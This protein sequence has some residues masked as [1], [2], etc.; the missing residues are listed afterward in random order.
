MNSVK[1]IL[2]LTV[3][4]LML[5]LIFVGCSSD[6]KTKTEYPFFGNY[7]V[8]EVV[9]SMVNNQGEVS[10]S[11]ELS[12]EKFIIYSADKTIGDE[13]TDPEYIEQ[14][15][16]DEKIV[17]DYE[18]ID[19]SQYSSKKLYNITDPQSNESHYRIYLLDDDIWFSAYDYDE[20]RQQDQIMYIY[21][22]REYN[23]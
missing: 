7:I 8:S 23:K 3:S 22:L 20:A 1:K 4:I 18:E 2:S 9:Y 13:I 15:V 11:Y 16:S 5:S 17:I 12:D 19:I 21:K 6:K 14:T 10:N